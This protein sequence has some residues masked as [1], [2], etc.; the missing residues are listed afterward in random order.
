MALRRL[1]SGWLIA[2][3][4]L[5]RA[6][7]EALERASEARSAPASDPVMA[8][9][10]ERYP[11]APEH[12]LAHV[13]KRTAELAD[14]GEAPLSLTSDPTGWPPPRPDGLSPLSVDP[15][16]EPRGPTAP[17]RDAA[18]PTLAA[19]R[20]RASEVWRRPG[21]EPRRRPRPVFA[22]APSGPER[23]SRATSG[24]ATAAR[25]RPPLSVGDVSL[26]AFPQEQDSTPSSAPSLSRSPRPEPAWA[27]APPSGVERPG[28]V[29]QASMDGASIDHGPSD[30]LPK[31]VEGRPEPR[32]EA[33]GSPPIARRQRSWFFAKPTPSVRRGSDRA[34]TAEFTVATPAPPRVAA[35]PRSA[36]D[37]HA[38][39]SD[40]TWSY[41]AQAPSRRSIFQTL[42]TPG[43]SSRARLEGRPILER[44][45]RR[46]DPTS[47]AP[48]SDRPTPSFAPS[49]PR[50]SPRDAAAF[51]GFDPDAPFRAAGGEACSPVHGID[52]GD[53]RPTY[54]KT[55]P[56]VLRPA[57]VAGAVSRDD[58]WPALPPSTFAPPPAVEAA[59]PRWDQLAR[60]QEEGRWSV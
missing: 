40:Q 19:L 52:A 48:G 47:P 58:R 9:L 60:E 21:V 46:L 3:A 42:A 7:A 6:V 31:A 26:H 36:P 20:D 59:P 57:R 45:A 56:T 16:P 2:M 55:G 54:A 12:W 51:A 14:I 22:A 27:K 24:P 30:Q 35:V 38:V 49:S 33:I 1:L 28:P 29:V 18:V 25:Q 15:T 32:P 5:A 44:A 41:P 10:A 43:R 50:P 8:A 37:H 23:P 4:A 53:R 17:Q 11:G 34:E 13:A 39:V